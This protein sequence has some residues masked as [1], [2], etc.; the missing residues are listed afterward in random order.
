MNVYRCRFFEWKRGGGQKQPFFVYFA[1]SAPTEES[2]EVMA[3][4]GEG[5]G[6]GAEGTSETADLC[7]PSVSCIKCA[8]CSNQ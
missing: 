1:D 5:A 2:M 3:A 4:E 8:A 6:T 7:M